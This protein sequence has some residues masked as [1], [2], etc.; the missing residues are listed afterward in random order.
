MMR[1]QF[2]SRRTR[3]PKHFPPFWKLRLKGKESNRNFKNP[4]FPGIHYLS[5]CK[6]RPRQKR[7]AVSPAHTAC[8]LLP[9]RLDSARRPSQWTT[10]SCPRDSTS[11]PSGRLTMAWRRTRWS[12][13]RRSRLS[14]PSPK[15]GSQLTRSAGRTSPRRRAFSHRAPLHRIWDGSQWEFGSWFQFLKRLLILRADLPNHVQI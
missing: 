7:D 1:F 8:H 5:A 2:G 14:S 4:G 3:S 6:R 10:H 12:T 11:R 9:P 13:P 15:T